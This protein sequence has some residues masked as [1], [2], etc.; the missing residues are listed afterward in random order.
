MIEVKG[1]EEMLKKVIEKLKKLFCRQPQP[2]NVKII[3]VD[4]ATGSDQ[5]GIIKVT[6]EMLQDGSEKLREMEK[7]ISEKT[8][9]LIDE[10]IRQENRQ[11][12]NNWRKMHGLPMRRRQPKRKRRTRSKKKQ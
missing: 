4:L 2:E 1:G 3:G 6:A 5:T 10:I 12:T 8:D 7:R 9:Q 11:N